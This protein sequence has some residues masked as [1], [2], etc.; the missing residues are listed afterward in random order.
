MAS[1]S[2]SVANWN[3]QANYVYG[4][5]VFSD[6]QVWTLIK[7]TYVV[8]ISPYKGDTLWYNPDPNA[9][10]PPVPEAI[11]NFIQ[12]SANWDA[13]NAWGTVEVSWEGGTPSKNFT[14]SASPSQPNLGFYV[15]DNTQTAT[16]F[17]I[18]TTP[19]TT[20]TLTLTAV[21]E[22]GSGDVTSTLSVTTLGPPTPPILT[23]SAYSIDPST[24]LGSVSF[25]FTENNNG[26]SNVATQY[27]GRANI[28]T[29]SDGQPNFTFS[30][31]RANGTGRFD[32]LTGPLGETPAQEYDVFMVG[33]NSVGVGPPSNQLQGGFSPTPPLPENAT[34]FVFVTFLVGGAD[35]TTGWVINTGNNPIIGG[36]D[37]NTG[38]FSGPNPIPYLLQLR[39]RGVKIMLSL[40]GFT[41][42]C[43]LGLTNGTQLAHNIGHA[44]FGVSTGNWV[45]YGSTSTPANPF[46]FDGLDLD[47]EN[48]GPTDT[49]QMTSFIT[50]FRSIC[51]RVF[52]SMS[53]QPPF[54]NNGTAPFH[55]SAFNANGAY[56]AFPNADSPVTAFVPNNPATPALLDKNWLGYFDYIFVQYYNNPDWIPGS[57]N[58]PANL[59]QWAKMCQ[60]AI[61][62]VRNPVPTLATTRVVI[63]FA[64]ADGTPIYSNAYNT[65]VSNALRTTQTLI[66]SPS[67]TYFCA[68]SG[69][70]NSPTAQDMF[71]N[72]IY[73]STTG[74]ELLPAD[75]IF[76]YLNQNAIDPNWSVLPI[77]DSFNSVLPA[78]TSIQILKNGVLQTIGTGNGPVIGG[79]ATPNILHT[80]LTIDFGK[81]LS[82]SGRPYS[83][84][85]TLTMSLSGT[86]DNITPYVLGW[87]GAS[88]SAFYD[89]FQGVTY[90]NGTGTLN[91]NTSIGAQ[92]NDQVLTTAP[93]NFLMLEG[94]RTPT[95]PTSW[96]IVM[97]NTIEADT[98]YVGAN[99]FPA[100]GNGSVGWNT[101]DTNVW[102]NIVPRS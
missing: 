60:E 63:G 4:D 85:K 45:P 16:V 87:G 43:S 12:T 39:N 51:P 75:V 81:L 79:F 11:T 65:I 98:V 32:N 30:Y 64:S 68:G 41:F 62:R 93:T 71:V 70:W 23:L 14:F 74:V 7:N 20:V 91:P 42:N 26:I 49:T 96:D 86:P 67:I 72:V 92:V 5:T 69:L 44:F 15:D 54:N 17:G 80:L 66:N 77:L 36:Y 28:S 47:W 13:D 99:V 40:G 29:G 56:S 3:S 52:L 73:D 19:G 82:P 31:N 58:F 2:A 25:T 27:N 95:A 37:C 100:I 88:G 55:S 89:Y 21:S 48:N 59:A 46:V 8:G 38:A 9:P 6:G 83:D 10:T 84:C 34:N 35:L 53:P 24:G 1:L 76:M 97:A 102:L 33:E 90:I 50:E 57:Q 18:G 94:S 101:S 61:P 78:P 22:T